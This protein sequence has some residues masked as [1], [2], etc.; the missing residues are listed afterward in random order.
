MTGAT[1]FKCGNLV[2]SSSGLFQVLLLS[3][4]LE[5]KLRLL[6]FAHILYVGQIV[7]KRKKSSL[8]QSV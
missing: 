3:D 7:A 1:F 5:P 6:L 8:L 4:Q 2:P